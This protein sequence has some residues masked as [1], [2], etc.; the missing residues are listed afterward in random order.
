MLS[1]QNPGLCVFINTPPSTAKSGVFAQRSALCYAARISQFAG[2]FCCCMLQRY[3]IYYNVT[4]WCVEQYFGSDFIC[5]SSVL[6]I[7]AANTMNRHKS[8]VLP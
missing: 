7:H 1:S 8:P 6:R 3:V 2:W 5:H 4:K